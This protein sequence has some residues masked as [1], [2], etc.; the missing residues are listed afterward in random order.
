M[1]K[2]NPFKRIPHTTR[3]CYWYMFLFCLGLIGF[4]IYLQTVMLVA[5][6]PMCEMQRLVFLLIAFISM[7]ALL[8]KPKHKGI[9]WFGSITGGLSLLGVLLA[10]H[11][12]WL[13]IYPPPASDVC[14]VSLSYL[15]K[16]L[17]FSSAV[18]MAILGTGD[19]AKVT[20]R[21][22]GL[23]IPAWSFISYVVLG[24]LS[25]YS[26]KAAPK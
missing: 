16:V 6:C 1:F 23:S 14:G 5:P 21:L 11:Q 15:F 8:L 22:L 25:L 17:P 9:C 24:F 10:G 26:I 4:A 2:N 19:C 7:I 12:V 3:A 13:E 20:W 18:K